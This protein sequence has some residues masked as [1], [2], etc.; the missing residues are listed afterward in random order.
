MIERP[1]SK[2]TGALIVSTVVGLLVVAGSAGASTG[3]A[4]RLQGSPI[5]HVVVIYQEN[6]SFN[7]L[8]GKLC[9]DEG[10]RCVATD[11]GK[12]STGQSIPLYAEPDVV[13]NAGHDFQ[14]QKAAIHGGEMDGWDLM[15]HG[16]GGLGGQGCPAEDD[17]PCLTQAH[18]GAS[19]TVW[20][21][22]DTYAISDMTFETDSVPS[23]GSHMELV[24]GTLDGFV[25]NE[26]RG[27]GAGGGCDSGNDA[28]WQLKAGATIWVPS[29]VPDELGNGPYRPSP[30]QYVP[31]IMDRIEDAGLTW[32]IW[33]PGVHG[34]AGYGWAICPTFYECLG[35]DQVKKVKESSKFEKVAKKG[36]LPSLSYLIP[37]PVNSQHN[38]K[39][40]IQ[41]DDWIAK[42]VSAIMSG[43]DWRSTAIFITWDDCGCFYDPV[44]PPPGLGIRVPM[45]IVSPY[46]KPHFVDSNVS[47]FASMLAF[48]EH[49]FGLPP[50]AQDDA[51]AYDFANAFDFTQRP[52]APIRLPIHRV[53]NASLD[54]IATHP[55]GPDDDPT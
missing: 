38:G 28:L 5:K 8:L 49:V 2:I 18:A 9:L 19:P 30:V 45:L 22:A 14:S 50:L 37:Y 29:C 23:W 51:N 53:P 21:L 6:H 41:G 24:S 15:P 47:S 3:H 44:A 34:G 4:S 10:N 32:G 25:G 31:T 27:S 46:A 52:L 54:H 42:N 26:T 7:E 12:I 20:S 48:T 43:K 13:P 39:S 16:S 35:S 33:A 1:G 17:Y 40:L 55:T 11:T 36:D